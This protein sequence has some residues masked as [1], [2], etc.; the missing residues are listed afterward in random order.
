MI[1]VMRMRKRTKEGE[2]LKEGLW[3]GCE[4]YKLESGDRLEEIVTWVGWGLP[5]NPLVRGNAFWVMWEQGW[6]WLP[7]SGSSLELL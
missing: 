5:Y 2:G 7:L 3:R 6:K 4:A 1:K